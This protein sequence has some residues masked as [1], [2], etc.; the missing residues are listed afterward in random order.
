MKTK[1]RRNRS[2]RATHIREY[3]LAVANLSNIFAGS[4]WVN[5]TSFESHSLTPKGVVLVFGLQ[6]NILHY[7]LFQRNQPK[8]RS[9]GE[10]GAVDLVKRK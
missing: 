7:L 1:T 2:Q 3:P 8:R 4:N 9:V 6:S 10:Y 5:K